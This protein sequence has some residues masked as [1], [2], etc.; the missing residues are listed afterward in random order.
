MLCEDVAWC[1][2][3]NWYHSFKKCTFK[4]IILPIPNEV[5]DYLKSDGSLILPKE[6]N[7]D[8]GDDDEAHQCNE[9]EEPSF[10]EYNAKIKEAIEKLGNAVF[11]KLNWSAPRDAAWVGVAH[12]LKC[13]SLAQIWM[14]LK[15]S[16]FIC[17]DLTQPFKDCNDKNSAPPVNYVLALKK[18]SKD[19]NPATEFRCFVRDRTLIAV[20]QRDASNYYQHVGEEKQ[21]ILRDIKSFFQEH[22]KHKL[23]TI[24]NVVMDVTRPSKDQVKLIDFNPF[25]TTT[26]SAMFDWEELQELPVSDDVQFRF[27][28]SQCGILPNSLH[29]YSLPKDIVDL[30]CGTDHEK[31]V[32]FLQLQA[33]M[34]QR[35][36]E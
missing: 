32:D 7:E 22:V 25:G 34:Q 21:D 30:A 29:Q 8:D 13:D 27:V 17:H 1:S 26:D 19:I 10:P 20:E 24:Q 16:D 23:D 4:T 31:L 28:Q 5:L 14:L 3:D 2:I 15:S 6:C 12:S 35:E 18:W 33:D 11:P 36:G 9:S